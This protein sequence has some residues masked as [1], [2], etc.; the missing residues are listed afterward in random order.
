MRIFLHHL[1][2]GLLLLFLLPPGAT[3]QPVGPAQPITIVADSTIGTNVPGQ[4]EV[5]EFMGHVRVT[6]GPTQITA[7][8]GVYYREREYALLTGNVRVTQPG[9]VLTA[10]RADYNGMSKMASA[11]GGVTIVDSGATLHASAVDYDIGRRIAYFKDGV[12]LRDDRATLKARSG[13]Y[14]SLDMRAEFHGNVTV[15]NDSGSIRSRELTYWRATREAFAVG[16]VRLNSPQHGTQLFGDTLRDTPARR[17]TFVS[18]SPRLVR[19]DTVTAEDSPGTVR[20]DTTVIVADLMEA[21]RAG[22][23]EYVAT[24]NVNVTRGGLQ[25]VA[26]LARFLPDD[27]VIA[28]GPGRA[29]RPADTSADSSVSAPVTGEPPAVSA[30]QA[31]TGLPGGEPVVWYNESQLT[32]DTITVGLEENRLRSIDV[33]GNGFAVTLGKAAERYDQLAGHRLFFDIF[34]DTIRQVRSEGLASSIYFIYQASEPDGVNRAS[35]DTIV[36]A[37]EDAEASRVKIIG[38]R[39]QLEGEVIPETNVRGDERS[40]R[41]DGFRWYSRNGESPMETPA[42]SSPIGLPDPTESRIQR[43]E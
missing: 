18:G 1:R 7:D 41:L 35:G 30:P 33:L 34:R 26:A 36:V 32:G 14:Y 43:R 24:R 12:T 28:L 40:Y 23:E 31:Q 11:S 29:K 4:E 6:Q 25:A 16:E 2:I 13:E 19:I 9:M 38:G 42:E 37:F 17:Y 21:F 27:D 10:P 39:S 8:K 3:A 20:R 15:E 5:A 22:R